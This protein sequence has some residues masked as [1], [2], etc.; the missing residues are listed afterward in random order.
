MKWSRYHLF[1]AAFA[2]VF[3]SYIYYLRMPSSSFVDPHFPDGVATF[4]PGDAVCLKYTVQRLD[5]CTL[6]IARYLED[7][8]PDGP[9]E[10]LIQSQTQIITPGEPRP[11][12]FAPCPTVPRDMMPGRY[13]LFPR[14]RYYCNWTDY[15]K[16]RITNFPAVEI[17]VIP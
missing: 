17:M 12:G 11:S 13:R 15:V 1:G 14:V 3:V 4:R 2:I 9:K 6:E 7:M 16:A 10:T 8:A 5:T